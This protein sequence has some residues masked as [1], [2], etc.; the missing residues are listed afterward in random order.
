M[1]IQFKSKEH[2][3]FYENMM[4]Q[5]SK[6]DSYHQ[7]LFYTLG[8]CPDCRKHIQDLYDV[9]NDKIMLDGIHQ[10]WQTSGSMRTTLLA[11]NLWNGFASENTV[12]STPYD[13]FQSEDCP[14]YFEAVKI[15]YPEY[16]LEHQKRSREER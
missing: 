16:C 1:K 5:C 13:L 2:K 14:F 11:F 15:K 9:H 4:K 10:Y 8:I 12:E 7:T 6:N 3:V